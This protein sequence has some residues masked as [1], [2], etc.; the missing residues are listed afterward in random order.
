MIP[1]VNCTEVCL[2]WRCP[3]K[4]QM[5]IR[6]RKHYGQLRRRAFIPPK[7]AWKVNRKAFGR[8]IT[9]CK[10]Y[11]MFHLGQA[12]QHVINAFNHFLFAIFSQ[13]A[14][15]VPYKRCLSANFKLRFQ[16]WS[17][18]EIQRQM[19]L[20]LIQ[21]VTNKWTKN[22]AFISDENQ[23]AI[24]FFFRVR[25]YFTWS[26]WV[27]SWLVQGRGGGVVTISLF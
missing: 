4:L 19:L 10:E 15:F 20:D 27:K 14:K 23:N 6:A 3:P 12:D 13:Q 9:C 17:T 8:N 26:P 1:H 16:I 5:P 11:N 21:I 18:Y 24:Y 25:P 2:T 7:N 22:K